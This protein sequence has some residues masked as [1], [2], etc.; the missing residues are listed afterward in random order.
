LKW[1]ILRAVNSN[2][3]NNIEINQAWE[4]LSLLG[5]GVTIDINELSNREVKILL[6]LKRQ[7][8]LKQERLSKIKK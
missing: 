8:D 4:L 5:L 2:R 3:T 6:E 1:E 7:I